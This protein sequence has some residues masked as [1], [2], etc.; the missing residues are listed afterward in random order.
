MIILIL[1]YVLVLIGSVIPVSGPNTDLPADA[2]KVVHFV[3]YG[4]SAI[5]L[6]RMFVK[7]TTIQRA[8]FLSVAIAALYG[9][10]LETVQYFLP[11]RSFSFGDMVANTAGAFSGSVLYMHGK[12]YET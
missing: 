10:T 8:F 2:D 11:Y 4:I 6:F 1:W 5:L 12:S 9:A 3:M 7:K